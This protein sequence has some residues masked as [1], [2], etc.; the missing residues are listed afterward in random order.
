M[1]RSKTT[2]TPENNWNLTDV[3]IES[4]RREYV[5]E[6]C[7]LNRTAYRTGVKVSV[8]AM[9]C[10]HHR[11]T[12]SPWDRPQHIWTREVGAAIQHRK[13]SDK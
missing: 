9:V 5:E 10:K 8:V 3:Q 1:E 13:A 6:R 12:R 7:T 4:V 2:P 11:W